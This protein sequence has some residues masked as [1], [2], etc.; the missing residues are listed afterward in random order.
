MDEYVM[1]IRKLKKLR[2]ILTNYCGF[3]RYGKILLRDYN[4]LKRE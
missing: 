2:H 1:M 3:L 4:N